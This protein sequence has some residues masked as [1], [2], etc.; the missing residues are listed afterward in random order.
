MLDKMLNKIVELTQRLGPGLRQIISNTAWM[1]SEKIIQLGLSLLVGVWVTRY[2]GPTQFGT[3][4]YA[5]TFVSMFGAI[6]SL[7]ALG[8][9]L[10]RDIAIDPTCKDETLGTAFVLQLM[11][12]I[13]TV[14]LAVGTVSLVN[15][16][17]PLTHWLV[18]ILATGTIFSAFNTIDFWFQSQLQSKY[19]G[20]ARNSA[21]VL[22]CAVRLLLIQMKAQLIMFVWASFVEMALAGLGL[23]VMYRIQGSSI[24]G[25]RVSLRR[26]KE[27]LQECWP[28]IVSSFAIYIYADIDQLMLGFLLKDNKAQLGFYAAAVK[29]SRL[30]DTFPMILAA[31]IVPKLARLKDK[32]HE[33]YLQKIQIYFDVST[34]F[35][36]ATAIP[37]SILSPYIVHGIYGEKFSASIPVLSLYVWSQFNAI[38]GVARSSVLTIEKKLHLMPIF[39][40]IGAVVNIV[41]NYFFIPNYGAMGATIATIITYA[42]VIFLINFLIKDLRFVGILIV[43]SLNLYSA[44]TRLKKLVQ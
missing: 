2:L 44:F 6:T 27:L 3:L 21:Y 15:P 33:D 1:F 20:F 19:T 38:W 36:I 7:G 12:G 42:V 22:M 25:W 17:E 28:L 24:Q 9:L 18:A 32:N 39:T 16:H 23:A 13:V 10:V 35:W 4:T 26:A 41:L 11:S 29:I 8:T 5:V 34:A 31:S 43:R 14:F 30:L 40:I 37:V